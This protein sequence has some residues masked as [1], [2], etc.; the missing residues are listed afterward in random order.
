MNSIHLILTLASLTLGSAEYGRRPEV[1]FDMIFDSLISTGSWE[2]HSEHGHAFYPQKSELENWTP[3]REGQWHYTDYGWTWKGKEEHDWA[4]N[5]YG[6]WTKEKEGKWGW[7]AKQHWLPATVEWLGSGEYIGWRP[8]VV[9]RFSNME[10]PESRRYQNP[11]EWNF[12]HRDKLLNPLSSNDFVDV[13]L[14][15]KLLKN[16]FPLDHIFKSYREIPRPGPSLPKD[17]TSPSGLSPILT[18]F[19]ISAPDYLPVNLSSRK[20][21]LYRP[22]FFQDN[23][24]IAKRIELRLNPL[25]E[26]N[27]TVASE[28]KRELTPEE[29]AERDKRLRLEEKKREQR[30]RLWEAAYSSD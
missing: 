12:I 15:T 20:L 21:Y 13:E 14:T 25:P 17:A 27:P 23:A 19:S 29:K 4:L 28:F 22:V 7:V 2:T 8:S 16:S 24:G 6:F 18:L 5:H 10:E 9:D 26:G 1:D 11:E 30:E 3:Y